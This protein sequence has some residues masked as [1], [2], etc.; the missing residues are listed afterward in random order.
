[1]S[2]YV[3][4]TSQVRYWSETCLFC[5]REW[6][7]PPGSRPPAGVAVL[8]IKTSLLILQFFQLFAG[9]LPNDGREIFM[10]PSSSFFPPV[11][12]QRH[13][14]DLTTSL[15]CMNHIT[16]LHALPAPLVFLFKEFQNS[17]PSAYFCCYSHFSS[18]MYV[19]RRLPRHVWLG[20]KHQRSR[21]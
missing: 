2:G 4:R 15:C 16:F 1:M 18:P 11:S 14:R 9:P 3:F 21:W 7:F 20:I 8:D 17:I 12:F 10:A 13:Q 5:T 6:V 19:T